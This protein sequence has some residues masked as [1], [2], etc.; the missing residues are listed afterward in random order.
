MLWRLQRGVVLG[1][2]ILQTEDDAEGDDHHEEKGAVVLASAAALIG[3]TKLWQ[4]G[5]L[6]FPRPVWVHGQST[7]NGKW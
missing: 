3:I 5:F 4:E 7:S 2:P 6:R 1:A